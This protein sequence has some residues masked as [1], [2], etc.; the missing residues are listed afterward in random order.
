MLY[1]HYKM[2]FIQL[3]AYECY[4]TYA[5]ELVFIWQ[6]EWGIKANTDFTSNT[7]YNVFSRE[8]SIAELSVCFPWQLLFLQEGSNMSA[9]V[10]LFRPV[11]R[12]NQ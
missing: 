8:T 11:P 7:D 10:R 6:L 5:Q 3:S 1:T 9:S 4:V 12:G 2:I